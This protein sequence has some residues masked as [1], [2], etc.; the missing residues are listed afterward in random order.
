MRNEWG[1]WSLFVRNNTNKSEE[2]CRL[3]YLVLEGFAWG[4][5]KLTYALLTPCACVQRRSQEL[6]LPPPKGCWGSLYSLFLKLKKG[7]KL[8]MSYWRH[9]MVGVSIRKALRLCSAVLFV[10]F[11][12]Y[13]DALLIT[14]SVRTTIHLENATACLEFLFWIKKYIY[15]VLLI[16]PFEILKVNMAFKLASR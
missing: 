14:F 7:C 4:S 11:A 3:G 12:V 2:K 6:L 15:F 5:S 10:I 16:L 1:H 13:K 8:F 9:R